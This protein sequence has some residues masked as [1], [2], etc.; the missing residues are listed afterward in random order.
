V[1]M[2]R[3]QIMVSEDVDAR[4]RRLAEERGLTQS[5]LIAEAVKQLPDAQDQLERMR[6]FAGIINEGGESNLS[7]RVDDIYLRP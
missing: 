2:I 1:Q 4:I 3:K 7:T 5:A 6:R